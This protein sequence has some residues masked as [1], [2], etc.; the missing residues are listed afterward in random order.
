[1]SETVGCRNMTWQYS[2]VK[3]FDQ[4]SEMERFR[5]LAYLQ[6]ICKQEIRPDSMQNRTMPQSFWKSN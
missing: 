1:M 3:F 2:P 5:L 4:T 6:I